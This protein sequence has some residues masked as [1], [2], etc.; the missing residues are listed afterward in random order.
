MDPVTPE[1]TAPIDIPAQRGGRGGG[2]R[3]GGG[4]GGRRPQNYLA[5]DATLLLWRSEAGT[6]FYLLHGE[7]PS[8]VALPSVAV[9]RMQDLR[10]AD[11][12]DFFADISG[13][14]FENRVNARQIL[15]H[16]E[17][18]RVSPHVHAKITIDQPTAANFQCW[19]DSLY[20]GGGAAAGDGAVTEVVDATFEES[21]P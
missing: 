19:L 6:R 15:I 18:W 13:W 5:D 4:R 20:A 11:L 9:R 14:S 16:S 7:R 1:P 10:P 8:I 3:R 21:Q 17:D 2:R 12:H